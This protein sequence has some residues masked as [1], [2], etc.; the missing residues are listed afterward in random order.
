[1]DVLVNRLMDKFY[2]PEGHPYSF[3]AG[4]LASEILKDNTKLDELR[5][6]HQKYFHLNNMFVPNRLT[7][8]NFSDDST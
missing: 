3:E 7:S 4:G 8:F 6:Y 1:M 5:Q 2:Y